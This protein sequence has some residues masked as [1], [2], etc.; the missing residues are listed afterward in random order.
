MFYQHGKYGKFLKIFFTPAI[1]ILILFIYYTLSCQDPDALSEDS[2][3]NVKS[4]PGTI[5]VS[6]PLKWETGNYGGIWRDT[7]K[8]DPKSYN[9]FSNLDGTHRTVTGLMLDYLFDYD[10]YT[11]EWSGNIVEKYEVVFD[12]VKD[13]MELRCTLRNNIYWSDGV[14]MTADDVVWWF[15]N[16][17]GDPDVFP[18]GYSGQFITMQDGSRKRYTIEQTGKLDFKYIFPRVVGNPTLVVNTG[19]II[20]K[21]IWEPVHRIDK[22]LLKEFWG[23]NTKPEELVGNG[24]FLLEEN[25]AG[26][27]I[28]FKR[29]PNYWMSD[30]KGNKLPYIDRIILSQIHD[31]NAE[32]LKFQKGETESYPMRGEDMATLVREM[33]RGN[34]S[35]WNGG[36]DSGYPALIFNHNPNTVPENKFKLFTNQYFKRA[37]S[38]IIDRETIINLTINGLA[39]PLHHIISES[40]RFYNPDLASPYD[41]NPERAA[42]LFEKAGLKQ[43]NRSG[44]FIDDT[45]NPVSFDILTSSNDPVLHDYLNIIVTDLRKAGLRANIVVA[46]FNAIVQKL[47]YTG[48][49]DCYLAG[50][51]F[52]IFPEQWYNLWLSDGNRHYWNPNQKEPYL[53]WQKKIDRLYNTL[54]YTY[55]EEK[56]KEYY[57]EFQKTLLDE[58]VIIPLFRRYTF[59]A[60]RNKWGNINW[61]FGNSIG[62]GYRK[63][64]LKEEE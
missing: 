4:I 34:F 63:I 16:I 52:P 25:R 30:E 45:G 43:K 27:R 3:Y 20:P 11:R 61:G 41:Y 33:E 1:I 35:I 62:D 7:Y 51:N 47:L 58:L 48:E 56:I 36:P 15:D 28:V 19:S 17:E 2:E 42:E 31:T 26:E 13:T 22:N 44:F 12:E 46:D 29:N 21:H 60:F 50:F 5:T 39:E 64:Y 53:E 59:T 8:E 38:S 55:R 37:I 54:V 18:L 57:D 23:I 6:L 14:Q 40:N 49:W 32:L 9:P 10:P 24:P